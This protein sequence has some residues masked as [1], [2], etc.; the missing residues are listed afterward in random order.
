MLIKAQ[1]EQKFKNI[2]LSSISHQ[3]RTPLNSLYLNN[4]VIREI[5]SHSLI[6]DL[7]EQND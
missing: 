7:L 6:L 3:L 2:F 4:S 1:L 5:A